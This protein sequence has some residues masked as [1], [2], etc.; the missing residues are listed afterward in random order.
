MHAVRADTLPRSRAENNARRRPELRLVYRA[1]ASVTAPPA[2]A[3]PET[4]PP[5]APPLM[6][7]PARPA[8]A[9]QRSARPIAARQQASPPLRLTRRGRV[10][11]AAAVVLL[12]AVLSL[13]AAGAAQ[14]F[15]H[16]ASPRPAGRALAQVVVRPG[17]SLWSVAESADPNADTRLVSQQIIELNA[18]SDTT[19][20]VGQR[21]W[22]PRS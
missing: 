1:D 14:A 19:V 15:S 11:V 13:I 10:V 17:Q 8:P 4:A 21:L 9:R 6:P 2:A 3:L 5:T 18:L 22:V 16:S 20:F 7:A 12:V